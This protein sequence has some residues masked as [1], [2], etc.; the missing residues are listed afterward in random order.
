MRGFR[1]RGRGDVRAGDGAAFADVGE[2]DSAA[3][4]GG[5][6]CDYGGAVGEA[7]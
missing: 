3:E 6:A 4:A 2:G 5:C 1:A 7:A